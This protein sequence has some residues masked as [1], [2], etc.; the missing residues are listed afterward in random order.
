MPIRNV[1][2][3][4]QQENFVGKLVAAGRYQSADEVLREG[5]RLFEGQIQRHRPELT[6]IQ[7]RVITG[8]DQV[9][10]G[11]FADGTGG[12]SIERA[13]KRAVKQRAV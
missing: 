5:L 9:E 13:F 2:L 11:E 4:R 7:D 12:E 8:F 10:H 3:T 6:N 1:V